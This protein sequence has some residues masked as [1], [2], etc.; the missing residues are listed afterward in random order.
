MLVVLGS[1]FVTCSGRNN[2]IKCLRLR[3]LVGKK[4]WSSGTAS[5]IDFFQISIIGTLLKMDNFFAEVLAS[6]ALFLFLLHC[7]KFRISNYL[8]LAICKTVLSSSRT[9]MF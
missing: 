5:E 1:N 4:H 3:Y 2:I 6:S 8:S 9:E 7:I